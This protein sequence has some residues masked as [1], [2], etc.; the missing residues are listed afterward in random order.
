MRLTSFS[1]E[2]YGN[3]EAVRLSLDPQPGHINLVMAPNGGGKTV[4]R[5]A[6]GNLLFDLPG[7][8]EMAFRFGYAG[9]RLFAEGVDGRDAPFAIGR[10]KG[11]GNTLIDAAGNSLDPRILKELI[12]GA[13][14]ALFERLFALDGPLL[15]SGAEAMLASGGDI[16]E[17]LFAAGSGIAGVRRLREE[18]ESMR[19]ELAPGRQKKSCLFYQALDALTKARKDLSAF[20][21]RPQAWEELSTKLAFTLDR[22]AALADAHAKGQVGIEQLQRIKLVR[23]WLEQLAGARRQC[24]ASHGAPRLPPD[25]EERWRES[26]QAVELA[27]RERKTA[28]DRLQNITTTLAAEQPDRASCSTKASGSTI[29]SG[30]ATRS[31]RITAT[32]PGVRPS[33]GKPPRGFRNCCRPSKPNRPRRSRESCQTDRAS[34][35]RAT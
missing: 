21:I 27:E 28:T 8:T 26:R 23:P 16:A 25:I 33:A 29:W 12:G 9:M 3:F 31:L 19:E 6:L 15:R 20:T 1:L 34:R 4:L 7:R 32:C 14:E 13:D 5:R 30:R 35:R 18:L 2:K 22:R 17:A 10:R 11:T 24:A